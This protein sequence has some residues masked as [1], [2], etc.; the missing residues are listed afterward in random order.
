MCSG[1]T[2]ARLWSIGLLA[3]TLTVVSSSAPAVAQPADGPSSDPFA[4]VRVG[5]TVFFRA[6]DGVHGAELWMGDGTAA[7]TILVKD[8]FPGG[9][10]GFPAGLTRVGS[11]VFFAANDGVHGHELW[12][13]DGTEA[14]TVMVKDI[15]PGPGTT[16]MTFLRA[17]GSELFF[18]AETGEP[19]S[20][21]KSDGTE[22]GTVEV[23][24]IGFTLDDPNDPVVVGSTLFFVAFDAAQGLELWKSD[25]TPG[26]TSRVKSINPGPGDG[27][28]P[29][30][31]EPWRGD[32]YFGGD[33]GVHGVE[34]WRTDGTEA[35]TRMVR[36]IKPGGENSHSI[37]IHLEAFGSRLLFAADDG[38]RGRELWKSDG[39]R[40]GTVL[41]KDL[42][43]AGKRRSRIAPILSLDDDLALFGAFGEGSL[44]RT[45][46]SAKGTKVVRRPRNGGPA[47][48]GEMTRVP[49]IGVLFWSVLNALWKSDGT[50][51]GTV[52]VA[53]AV[54]PAEITALG[55]RRA[56]F[57]G[58]DGVHGTELWVTDGT[59][60]G[61]H[62]VLDIN[63]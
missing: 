46:G 20:L 61:T 39:T 44:H 58:T 41:V 56:L 28:D 14:G 63:P 34:L 25:G 50:R 7:G 15:T 10:D 5:D 4:L 30:Y 51:A 35:G 42:T 3:A 8:I 21:W 11:D 31:L 1:L 53:A 16:G 24:S 6:D 60:A 13:S 52:E 17:V 36:D 33:D 62:M 37:P 55:Q 48:V 57:A 27:V 45:D 54:D 22:G 38:E 32:V 23:K 9:E 59:P 19:D 2:K 40:A 18:S 43:P 49:G 29:F 12:K 47:S 26:G